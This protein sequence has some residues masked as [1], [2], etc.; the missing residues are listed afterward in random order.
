[1][2]ARTE[3][4]GLNTCIFGKKVAD[5]PAC[6]C[7]HDNETV[8]YVLLRCDKYAEVHKAL[9][10]AAGDRWGHSSY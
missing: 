2:Q 6:E 7:G 9:L 3:H 1:M 10:E 4:C 8:L 5:S